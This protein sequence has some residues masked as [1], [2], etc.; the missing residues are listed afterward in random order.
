MKVTVAK[1]GDADL[2]AC[3]QANCEAEPANGYLITI[4]KFH[5]LTQLCD[6]HA[7]ELSQIVNKE[8]KG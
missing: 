4:G 3:M 5:L 7:A 8:G 2:G 6:K 1:V